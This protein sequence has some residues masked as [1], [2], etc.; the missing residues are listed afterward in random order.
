MKFLFVGL[1]SMGQRHL[2]NLKQIMG[3]TAEVYAYRVKKNQFVLDNKLQ[4]IDEIGLDDKYN[5]HVVESMEQAW[6]LGVECVFICNPSSL[7]MD[8]LLKAAENGCHI[9]VEKPLSHNYENMEKLTELLSINK[10]ISFVGYQNRFHPCIRKTKKLLEDKSIGRILM[11]NAEIGEN[12][13]NWHK[14]EDYRNMY[15]CRKELGGGVVLTQIHE[16]DYII[17]FFGM[18]QN[19]YAVGG[20]LSDLEIDVE[21]VASVLLQ[22]KVDGQILPI[23]IQE[24]YIQTPP[25]RKCRIVG[26]EGKIEFDLLASELLVYDGLGNVLL[27]EKYNFERNDMFIEE[28]RIFL[29][30]VNGKESKDVITLQEGAESLKVA[31]AIKESLETGKVVCL[32]G[33]VI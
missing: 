24:D 3:D 2:R 7:H 10:C 30:A 13:K 17:Y 6:E 26:T 18:P 27:H 9:F 32:E 8:I 20:K 31:L 14:Y 22:Y 16:L 28:M 12:V 21:D 23:S 29:D 11:V 25:T 33:E 1:G 15:A 4:I 5:V 19:A